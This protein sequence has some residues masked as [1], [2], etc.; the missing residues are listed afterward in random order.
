M[1]NNQPKQYLPPGKF[2]QQYDVAI[3]KGEVTPELLKSFEM[4]AKRS[5]SILGNQV[6]PK[7]KDAIISYGVERAW[8]KWRKYDEKRTTNIFAFF[9]T[10]ITNDMRTK[11][12]LIFGKNKNRD[13]KYKFVNIDKLFNGQKD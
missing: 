10:M 4:I 3:S 5:F 7:D 12:N 6:S 9:T 2:Q 13:G 11:Y 1:C 8:E